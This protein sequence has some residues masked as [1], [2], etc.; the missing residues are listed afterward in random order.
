MKSVGYDPRG[1][2]TQLNEGWPLTSDH[3]ISAVQPLV[4]A[5]RRGHQD[6]SVSFLYRRPYMCR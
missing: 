3:T 1:S 4:N 6:T 2:T 5:C